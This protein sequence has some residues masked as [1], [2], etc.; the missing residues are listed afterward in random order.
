MLALPNLHADAR[1]R[2]EETFGARHFYGFAHRCPADPEALRQV[3]F[4][5]QHVA[6]PV[7]RAKYPPADGA[8]HRVVDFAAACRT[9]FRRRQQPARFRSQFGRVSVI[10]SGA[11]AARRSIR[12]RSAARRAQPSDKR[13]GRW[14]GS[15]RC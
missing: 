15:C 10:H 13:S 9:P 5:R 8:H 1:P 11:A 4:A 6:R 14:S 3:V 12:R 2:L 7:V